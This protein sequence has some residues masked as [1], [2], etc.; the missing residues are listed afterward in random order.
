MFRVQFIFVCFVN[1]I[2]RAAMA[3]CINIKLF[4]AAVKKLLS[5]VFVKWQI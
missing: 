1:A 2:N 3:N 4:G 5:Q